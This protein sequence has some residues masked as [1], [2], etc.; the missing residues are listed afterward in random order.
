MNAFR[1]V[2]YRSLAI[3]KMASNILNRIIL[4]DNPVTILVSKSILEFMILAISFYSTA[5]GYNSLINSMEYCGNPFPR[6]RER[7]VRISGLPV[8]SR[9]IL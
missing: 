7:R 5:G 3:L 2:P 1:I 4:R 9:I 6:S 8:C